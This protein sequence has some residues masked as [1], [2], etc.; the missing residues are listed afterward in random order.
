MVRDRSARRG[1]RRARLRRFCNVEDNHN[2]YLCQTYRDFKN[3][4]SKEEVAAKRPDPN[5]APKQ[6]LEMHRSYCA[7]KANFDLV[8]CQLFRSKYPNNLDL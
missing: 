7:V 8:A 3:G 1:F 6:M 5:P 4:V 2:L